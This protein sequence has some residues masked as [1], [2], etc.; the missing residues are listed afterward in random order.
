MKILLGSMLRNLATMTPKLGLGK[1]STAPILL[2]NHIAKKTPAT[3]A[4]I[5]SL[6]HPA[7]VLPTSMPGLEKTKTVMM[8]GMATIALNKH[9]SVNPLG[10]ANLFTSA[11]NPLAPSSHQRL[12][13]NG[14]CT[15]TVPEP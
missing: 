13:R 9:R 10:A 1:Q 7:K 3:V 11:I 8:A 4:S 2:G 14:L 5:S 12:S 6:T 15:G